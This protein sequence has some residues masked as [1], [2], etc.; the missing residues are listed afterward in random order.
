MRKEWPLGFLGFL[1]L[2]GVPK[3]MN[4]G[5]WLDGLWLLWVIW[6]VYFIPVKKS[7]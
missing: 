2:I 3:L 5:D 6:F 7:N 1:S 4:G